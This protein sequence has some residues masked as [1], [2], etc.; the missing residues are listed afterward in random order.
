MN[1]RERPR[2]EMSA[3]EEI[4]DRLSD[5]TG[6]VWDMGGCL[7]I[8]GVVYYEQIPTLVELLQSFYD[9]KISHIQTTS[10]N[11]WELDI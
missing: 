1:Q 11:L 8:D 5:L 3:A 4:V 7:G 6:S 10:T 2:D 9:T